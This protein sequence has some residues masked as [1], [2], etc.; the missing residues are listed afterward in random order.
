MDSKGATLRASSKRTPARWPCTGPMAR[1]H[2]RDEDPAWEP[3]I[4]ALLAQREW[5]QRLAR[6][7]T[8]D[9]HAA[10]DVAQQVLASALARPP[11]HLAN[12]RSWL[13]ALVRSRA[14]DAARAAARRG[15]RELESSRI[16]RAREPSPQA[17][18]ERA[19]L[20][21]RLATIVVGL[22]EPYRSALVLVYFEGLAPL[23]AARRLG[24]PDAT[25]RTHVHRGLALVREELDRRSGGRRDAWLACV[26]GLGWDRGGA[27]SSAAA[28]V[29]AS[30]GGGTIVKT[31]WLAA[32]VVVLALGAWLVTRERKERVQAPPIVDARTETLAAPPLESNAP[33]PARSAIAQEPSSAPPPPLASDRASLEVDV[34][35]QRDGSPA[36]GVSVLAS[37]PTATERVPSIELVADERGHATFVNLP[38]G[39]WIVLGDRG[40]R[41][42]AVIAAG[43]TA[44]VRLE[45]ERGITAAGR[46]LLSSGDPVAGAT[47]FAERGGVFWPARPVATSA[48]DGR[49]EVRDLEAGLSTSIWA[50]HP[51]HAPSHAV[52]VRADGADDRELVLTLLGD[53]GRLD[54]H[55]VDAHGAPIERAHVRVGETRPPGVVLPGRR[56]GTR[57]PAISAFTDRDGRCSVEGVATGAQDV[58]VCAEGFADVAQQTLVQARAPTTVELVLRRGAVLRGR[59]VDEHGAPAPDA[60]VIASEWSKPGYARAPADALGRFT[61]DGLPPGELPL[62]ADGKERGRA[63][64]T[65]VLRDGETTEIELELAQGNVVEGR[66]LDPGDRP[67][68]GCRVRLEC[69]QLRFTDAQIRE[70]NAWDGN[71]NARTDEQGRFRFTNVPPLRMRVE[72]RGNGADAS[73]QPLATLDEIKVPARD[74]VLHVEIDVAPSAYVSGI[75]ADAQGR[76]LGDVEVTLHAASSGDGQVVTS[77]RTERETGRFRIGPLP[78]GLYEG[79][80]NLPDAPELDL[81]LVRLERGEHVDLGVRRGGESGTIELLLTGIEAEPLQRVEFELVDEIGQRSRPIKLA[82]R[83]LSQPLKPGDYT[84]TPIVDGKPRR[85]HATKLHVTRGER[86]E[87]TLDLGWVSAR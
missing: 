66:V 12:V 83:A 76:P 29:A 77:A 82:G 39:R 65:A 14:R 67:V 87:R 10:D 72:V 37:H 30:V 35:W 51:A 1:A 48:A 79:R 57:T 11:R 56:R 2:T 38:P 4:A 62:V 58:L 74:L 61:I 64:A 36:S 40:G 25:L 47:I 50:R 73:G 53:A 80:A 81:G 24:V 3:R 18:L 70:L 22:R 54:V 86:L 68:P 41:Q 19:E 5:I 33:P 85:E 45:I 32:A 23:D 52:N 63:R 55:V 60:E 71:R 16:D 8:G 17:A 44:R 78:A 49:F 6:G 7:L 84:L 34:V 59:V 15:R 42:E 31:K 75:V 9:A 28:T 13:G 43:E 21:Q 26:V 69:A 20:V 27:A 46:V